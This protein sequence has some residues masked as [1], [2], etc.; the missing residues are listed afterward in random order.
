MSNLLKNKLHVNG[1]DFNKL[2]KNLINLLRW[3]KP[4]GRLILL[5]P[6][7]WSLWLT[8]SAPPS[9]EL[10]MLILTGGLLVSASGCI[11]ND[12]WDRNFDS[13]VERTKNR[14]LANGDMSIRTALIILIFS[15][16]FSLQ[17][18]FQLPNESQL[19]CLKLSLIALIPILIYPSA[20]RWFK[21]PQLFLAICWGFAVLI[22]WAASEASLDGG[23]PLASCWLGT[24]LWTFGFDTV[25]AMSDK[26]DDKKLNLRSSAL[27]LGHN[28]YTLVSICYAL[29]S[30]LIGF[31]AFLQGIG[32]IFW[33]IWLFASICMQREIFNLK[34]LE[35]QSKQFNKHFRN[36]VFL[37]GLILLALVTGT[38]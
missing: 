15:L 7:G 13:K 23:F 19:L 26:S 21:Y 35:T 6:A 34:R 30:F 2:F 38:P 9:K 36:Q 10:V 14:P 27:S 20:K 5:I 29:T 25:Y 37:G 31:S 17:I 8:P 3:N 33:P 4:S 24:V 12:L 28:A 32:Y 1:L 11:A 16:F 22:P 18:I